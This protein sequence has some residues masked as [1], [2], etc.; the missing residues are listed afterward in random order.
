MINLVYHL[1]S[2]RENLKIDFDNSKDW[3][4]NLLVDIFYN[5]WTWTIYMYGMPSIAEKQNY[6]IDWNKVINDDNDSVIYSI[7]LDN[8]WDYENDQNLPPIYQYIIPAMMRISQPTQLEEENE[9][10]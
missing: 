2:S 3:S 5:N 8:D 7:D 9:D 10:K 6:D 1:F 4:Y